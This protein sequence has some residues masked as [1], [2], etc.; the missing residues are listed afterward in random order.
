MIIYGIRFGRKNNVSFENGVC[1]QCGAPG[2]LKSYDA[3]KF[4][5]IYWIPL[6]PLGKKKILQECG[7]CKR[8]YESSYR[9]WET[10]GRHAL[11]RAKNHFEQNLNDVEAG[12]EYYEVLKVY[13]NQ[14]DAEK[15]SEFLHDKFSGDSKLKAYF[16][17]AVITVDGSEESTNKLQEQLSKDPEDENTKYALGWSFYKQKDY[18]KAYLTLMS[19]ENPVR[20]VNEFHAMVSLARNLN[21]QDSYKVLTFLGESYPKF[22]IKHDPYNK[23]VAE[24]EKEL[25]IPKESTIITSGYRSY[26]RNQKLIPAVIVGAIVIGFGLYWFYQFNHQKLYITNGLMEPM[27]VRI[28]G[29]DEYTVEPNQFKQIELKAGSY[30]ASVESQG[31]TRTIDFTISGEYEN[32]T[33]DLAYVLNPYGAGIIGWEEIVY[34]AV[35]TEEGGSFEF[36]T[37]E[38]FATYRNI[39]YPFVE[40]P[41]EIK[42]DSYSSREFKTSLTFMEADP[43]TGSMLLIYYPQGHSQQNTLNYMEAQI[44]SNYQNEE[45]LELYD[46]L[47]QAY[48][49]QERAITFLN[50]LNLPK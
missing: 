37:G 47:S 33:D 20:T 22:V 13:G 18:E 5:H 3:T 23:L 49:E 43:M 48:G 35:P 25:N 30:Q 2:Q 9:D 10:T 31:Q 41:E 27:T 1:Q 7:S 39:D 46:S 14:K 19:I 4:F 44:R 21:A 15:F 11:E 36:H 42:I 6:I 38:E 24:R 26:K 12:L 50:E 17:D 45:Y 34:M 40:P 28:E 8:H 16:K 29:L 32:I